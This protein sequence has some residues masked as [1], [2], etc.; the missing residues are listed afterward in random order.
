IK[1][2]RRVFSRFD[3]TI[4]VYLGMIKLACTFIWLR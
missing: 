2:F 1:H 4:S 3:K